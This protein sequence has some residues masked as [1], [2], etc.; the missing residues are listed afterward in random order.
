M[1]T[2]KMILV[3]GGAMVNVQLL[4]AVSCIDFK[5]H[6]HHHPSLVLSSVVS[7]RRSKSPVQKRSSI[8]QCHALYVRA[9]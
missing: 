2:E 8:H 7:G 3:E 1:W 9:G 4:Y 5:H 6:H